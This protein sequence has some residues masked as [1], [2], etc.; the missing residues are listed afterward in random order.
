MGKRRVVITGLG[1][2]SP[3]GHSLPEILESVKSSKTGIKEITHFDTSDF[4]VKL[5][6]E[7][8]DL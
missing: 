5:A 4:Q 2:V 7:V 3:I 6:A 8:Q 1:A